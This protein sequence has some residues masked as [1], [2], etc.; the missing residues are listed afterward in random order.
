MA[1]QNNE[2]RKKRRQ[3]RKNKRKNSS[4][5]DIVDKKTG[6]TITP[7][8]NDKEKTKDAQNL[9]AYNKRKAEEKSANKITSV[10]KQIPQTADGRIIKRGGDG[11]LKVSDE[12]ADGTQSEKLYK[13]GKDVTGST[14]SGEFKKIIG[15]Y[16][17]DLKSQKERLK[18][19]ELDSQED[20]PAPRG[21]S[22]KEYKKQLKKTKKSQALK[23]KQKN[24]TT[25]ENVKQEKQLKKDEKNIVKIFNKR[26]DIENPPSKR[27]SKRFNRR[28]EG[29]YERGNLS[30]TGKGALESM[31]NKNE[32]TRV[33]LKAKDL[34]EKA[35]KKFGKGK[36]VSK[37]LK[38]R[39]AENMKGFGVSDNDIANRLLKFEALNNQDKKSMFTRGAQA[40]Y[41]IPTSGS[42][43]PPDVSGMNSSQAAATAS[44]YANQLKA[45]QQYFEYA[46]PV[47]K[48]EDYYPQVGRSIG[49]GTSSGEIIGSRTIY[50][51]AGV[52]APMG[53]YDARKRALAAASKSGV[54]TGADGLPDMPTV[55][56]QY[57]DEYEKSSNDLINE[58]L[59]NKESFKNGRLTSEAKSKLNEQV[60]LGRTINEALNQADRYDDFIKG[61]TTTGK[62]EFSK[63][64]DVYYETRDRNLINSLLDPETSGYDLDDFT[65]RDILKEVASI[66]GREFKN[67]MTDFQGEAMENLMKATAQDRKNYMDGVETG[68]AGEKSSDFI[69]KDGVFTQAYM[70]TVGKTR[71][72]DAVD[73]LFSSGV[74]SDEQIKETK[75]YAA[76][77]I[78]S[79]EFVKYVGKESA[80]STGRG[81][82]ARLFN[83][84][85]SATTKTLYG[86]TS[87]ELQKLPTGAS[88]GDITQIY[89]TTI[90]GEMRTTALLGGNGD[91]PVSANPIQ[92]DAEM[93]IGIGSV[94]NRFAVIVNG[95][96][97]NLTAGE[98]ANLIEERNGN[99]FTNNVTA[100]G[101][102]EKLD[103]KTIRNG[104]GNIVS[105][106]AT[107]FRAYGAL[108]QQTY[109]TVTARPVQEIN[110]MGYQDGGQTVV[111]EQGTLEDWKNSKNKV[112]MKAMYF[113]P[114]LQSIAAIEVQDAQ[115]K[116]FK[117]ILTDTEGAP[118]IYLVGKPII[119]PDTPDN[120]VNISL[121]NTLSKDS[122]DKDVKK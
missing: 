13:N 48:P 59:S 24:K 70:E 109:G 18:Q 33:G 122:T 40:G 25:K 79:K 12:K 2:E 121:S 96:Q 98:I 22:E 93:P 50:T 73:A 37:I 81:S 54:K 108:E 49:V 4:S 32:R 7:A 104:A 36:H 74:Y 31:S 68:I 76:A 52:L 34:L 16:E 62:G 57:R 101:S 82:K 83:K 47:L 86:T 23:N 30:E 75:K 5:K 8:S 53:L 89:A 69:D 91:A 112:Q 110:A 11:I 21:I 9:E 111:L 35:D 71:I 43:T 102:G 28:V 105:A 100:W 45:D 26:S 119:V 10:T 84:Q 1:K 94:S 63:V 107:W 116:N 41:G 27:K 60:K 113:K 64:G 65:R 92:S 118:S 58:I 42:T 51:G 120:A 46:N 115:N 19:L 88:N 20:V 6:L 55:R 97:R 106:D 67:L 3:E 44:M 14:P 77:Q 61:R 15:E 66:E 117:Q 29:I 114:N 87:P 56:R 72:D 80:P 103:A 99:T 17:K 95:V 90:G 38:K 78:G 39:I 85:F